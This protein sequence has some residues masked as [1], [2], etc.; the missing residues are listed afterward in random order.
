MSEKIY[1]QLCQKSKI[2]NNFLIQDTR[3]FPLFQDNTK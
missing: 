3:D 1:Y 2:L